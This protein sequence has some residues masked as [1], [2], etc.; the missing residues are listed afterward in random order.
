MNIGVRLKK[1]RNDSGLNQADFA[2]KIGV[3]QSFISKVEKVTSQLTV[4]HCVLIATIFGV[5]LNW[6]LTGEERIRGDNARI[7]PRPMD[8]VTEKIHQHLEQMCEDQKRDVL[9][10]TEE[11]KL[12]SELM[13]ERQRKA[14]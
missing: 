9:K 8:T 7:A 3:Q 14:G 5:D 4:E 10:Y 6:L 11:K 1:I 13:S 2:E 12:L